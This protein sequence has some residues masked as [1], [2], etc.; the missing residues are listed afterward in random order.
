MN[1]SD[2]LA[3]ARTSIANSSV[4]SAVLAR[5]ISGAGQTGY[6]RKMTAIVSDDEAMTHAVIVRASN[7]GLRTAL[8]DSTS[9]AAYASALSTGFESLQQTMGD[10]QLNGSPAALISK[11]Q[12]ALQNYSAS[13]QD[14][15]MP[16]TAV[17]AAQDLTA[18]LNS[19]AQTVQNVRTQA[20]VDMKTSVDKINADLVSLAKVNARIVAANTDGKDISDQLDAR[21]RLVADIAGEVG[22]SVTHRQDNSITLTTDSGIVLFDKEPRKLEFHRSTLTDGAAGQPATIDGA[23]ATSAGA[24][25]AI[26]TGRLAGLAQLRDRTTVQ[27]QSQIDGVAQSLVDAFAETDQTNSP[28]RPPAPGTFVLRSSDPVALAHQGASNLIAVNANIVSNP[29]RLRDGGASNPNDPA[30]QYNQNQSPDY[31]ARLLALTDALG[32]GTKGPAGLAAIA[33]SSLE[34]GRQAA[35]TQSDQQAAIVANSFD[36]LQKDVG[37]NLDDQLSRMLDVEHSYQASAKLISAIDGMMNDLLHAV[38]A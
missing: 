9:K 22:V 16:S 4:D 27:F 8:L 5:N 24:P 12:V 30:F 32:S 26:G 14:A 23:D 7:E 15:T 21:D 33:V 31:S 13:P 35:L 37:V 1:L 2:A 36:A 34:D 18:G 11:L 29:E 17:Q 3:S 20:D 6:S 19:A 10:G 25:M 38:G 28:T